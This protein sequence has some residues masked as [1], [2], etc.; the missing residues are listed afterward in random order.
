MESELVVQ[1]S[2]IDTS[3]LRN[4]HHLSFFFLRRFGIVKAYDL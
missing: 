2:S 3:R 1:G 4:K